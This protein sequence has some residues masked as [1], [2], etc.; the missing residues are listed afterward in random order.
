[1]IDLFR[2]DNV[3]VRSV[4]T[5]D[6][7]RWVVTFDNYGIGHGFER[8]GFGQDFLLASGISA[9]ATRSARIRFVSASGYSAISPAARWATWGAAMLVPLSSANRRPIT[10]PLYVESS[11]SP[12]LGT[13]MLAPA[14]VFTAQFPPNATSSGLMAP[15]TE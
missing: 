6:A 13:S 4:P 7:S 9:C 3:V 15:P 14:R 12:L 11:P 10:N 5:A 8:P 2:S 1:M